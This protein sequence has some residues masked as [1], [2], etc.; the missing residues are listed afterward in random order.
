CG[1]GLVQL[2]I[3]GVEVVGW[4]EVVGDVAGFAGVGGVQERAQEGG[5]G[6]ELGDD[7]RVVGG[8]EV[9]DV[10]RVGGGLLVLC[11]HGGHCVGPLPCCAGIGSGGAR[12]PLG[13][14]RGFAVARCAAGRGG[15]R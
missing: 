4:R 10:D 7:G 13:D 11:G 3:S 15:R 1:D 12:L 8:G 2:G 9:V 14:G 5:L 6:V